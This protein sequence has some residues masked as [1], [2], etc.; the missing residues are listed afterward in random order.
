[1]GS[2]LSIQMGKQRLKAS[3]PGTDVSWADRRADQGSPQARR[4]YRSHGT[5]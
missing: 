3:A 5:S 4:G 1:M 2:E